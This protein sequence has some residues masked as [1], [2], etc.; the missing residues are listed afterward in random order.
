M[1]PARVSL[2]RAA[3]PKYIVN[4]AP[5][6]TP[7]FPRHSSPSFRRKPESIFSLSVDTCARRGTSP[8]ATKIDPSMSVIPASLWSVT[9]ANAGIHLLPLR[10]HLR[11]AGDKPPRYENRP[12]HVR[13]FRVTLVRHSRERGNPSSPSPSNAAPGGGQAPALRKWPGMSVISASLWPVIPAKAG[14]HLFRLRRYPR[15]AGDK[16]RASL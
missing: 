15:P 14:I 5:H 1:H 4:P 7:L 3:L 11:P 12:Q 2:C 6:S 8:R 10:R 9:P 13:H 16:P